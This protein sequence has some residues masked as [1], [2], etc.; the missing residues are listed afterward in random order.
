METSTKVT[1][2]WKS[3]FK[4][5]FGRNRKSKV[6]EIPSQMKKLR[7]SNDMHAQ[8]KTFFNSA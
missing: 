5:A 4:F 8:N 6:F 3:V 2:L 1:R 7:K